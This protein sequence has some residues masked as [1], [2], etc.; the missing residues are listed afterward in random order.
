MATRAKPDATRSRPV[1]TAS[2]SMPR[3]PVNIAIVSLASSRQASTT[4]EASAMRCAVSQRGAC[5]RRPKR[6]TAQLY[7][8]RDRPRLL[9]TA[10]PCAC[11][12]GGLALGRNNI[13]RAQVAVEQPAGLWVQD[14][15]KRYG[16]KLAV[17]RLSFGVAPGEILGLAGPNGAGKTTTLLSLAGLL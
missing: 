16:A 11:F 4:S 9:R 5:Q 17:D 14:L 3:L 10:T 12:R 13:P 2:L 1:W 8:S 15:T 7:A 6:C